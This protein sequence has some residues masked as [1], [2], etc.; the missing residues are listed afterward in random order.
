MVK[1]FSTNRATSRTT[2]FVLEGR[3]E[4]IGQRVERGVEI[5]VWAGLF[6]VSERTGSG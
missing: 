1:R 6:G 3:A 5:D 2:L 4:G